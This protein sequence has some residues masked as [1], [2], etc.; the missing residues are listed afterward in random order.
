MTDPLQRPAG[1]LLC[2]AVAGF[3]AWP[4]SSPAQSAAGNDDPG[5]FSIGV[6]EVI[7]TRIRIEDEVRVDL[8][9]AGDIELHQ[10]TD[11]SEALD[12]MPGVTTQNDGGRG[13]R[14]VFVRGFNSRQVPLFIDGIPVYVPY[15]GNIDL[16][17]ITT[18]D[19]SEV[20]V[21]KGLTSVLYGPNA[22]GGSIN[23][24]TRRPTEALEGN[25]RLA[26]VADR[27]ADNSSLR[28]EARLATAREKWYAQVSGAWRQLDYFRLPDDFEPTAVQPAGDRINSASKDNTVNL[29]LGYTPGGTDEYVVSII[30]QRGEKGNPPYAG[31]VPGESVR[32]WKWPVYDKDSLYFLS[33][34]GFGDDVTL[35]L[36]AYR[37]TF[38]NTL[39]AYRDSTFTTRRFTSIYDDETLGLG[40]DVEWRAAERHT[41]RGALHYKDDEHVEYDLGAPKERFE[42]RV[43]SVAAEYLF[44]WSAA[45]S[46]TTG[47]GYNRQDGQSADRM[48]PDGSIVPHDTG[49]SD[50]VNAQ[51][52][53]THALDNGMR[54]YGGVARKTRFATIKDRYSERFGSA[55]PNPDLDVETSDNYELGIEGSAAKSSWKLALF[56]SRLEDAIEN[57]SLP[58][59]ACS[60]PPCSQLQNIAEQRNQGL[61]LSGQ[62]ALG[63]D[64]TVAGNYTWLDRENTSQPD[65]LPLDTPE[66]S[67]LLWVDWR[68][69]AGLSLMA[70][71]EYNSSRNSTTDGRRA[72]DDFTVFSVRGSWKAAS[73]LEFGAGVENLTDELY[74]YDEGYYESGRR[75]VVN[76]GFNF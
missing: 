7:G 70:S 18:A 17:R 22:L 29:R 46:V 55:L 5:K 53:L 40:A 58:A 76:V 52:V 63:A 44:A 25:L 45:T 65:L 21:S 66:H 69:V 42:D 32:W 50:A 6:I 49:S 3:A 28:T 43:W 60:S 15:D 2:L 51:V 72:T 39:V 48:L 68:P 36:R 74:A 59:T 14:L 9:D 30:R 47:L 37:D 10:R 38:D 61:E 26:T 33:R 23:V 35:R 31:S 8:L 20:V 41:L 12:L 16:A 34:T 24:I 1:Y 11:L 4:T 56:Y 57:V 13:E 27:Q 62:V 73:G 19:V 75:Y 71:G 54:A 67:A 64:W